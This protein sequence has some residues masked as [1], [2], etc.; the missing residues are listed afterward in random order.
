MTNQLAIQYSD[1]LIRSNRIDNLVEAFINAQDVRHSSRDAY[2]K[3][4]RAFT[5]WL[6]GH[7]LHNP[8]REDVLAYRD[9]LHALGLSP[10]T[11]SSYIVAVRKFFSFLESTIGY[12]NIASG[13][14]GAVRSRGFR[15]DPLTID[16]VRELLNSIDRSA[17]QGSR[18]YALLNLMLH[19]GLRTIEIIRADVGDI[20]Q[21][22]GEATLYVHGKGRDS[23]DEFVLL[24]PNATKPIYAYLQAR[25]K[26]H[27][28]NPLFVSLS[29][30]NRNA[31][32]TTKSIRGIVKR[33]LREIG[34]D[35]E[36]L[37]AHSLRHTF[38]TVALMNGAPLLQVKEALR[39]SSVETT[40]VYAH[41]LDRI[42]NA[43]EK[44]VS[45]Y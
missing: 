22:S 37:T 31:R 44:Y 34:I 11:V 21:Q 9:S 13:I 40:M 20:S 12:P 2:K 18:D 29:D 36:R 3:A 15:K 27:E 17:I 24:T 14:K 19:T 38:A 8:V 6:T 25:G 39:H 28:A 32:L 43:A 35:S 1:S 4:L 33:H 7:G 10:F 16:Q 5:G 26:V 23:K 41:S 42:K 30:R 45:F